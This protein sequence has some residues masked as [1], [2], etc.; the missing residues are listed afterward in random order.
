MLQNK[1]SIDTMKKIF[2]LISLVVAA[3]VGKL[4]AQTNYTLDLGSSFS[5]AWGAPSYSGTASNIGGS[6]INCTMA[7]ALTGSGSIVS[8]YPRV[9]NNNTNGSDFQVQGST[10]AMEID[11]N[12]GNKTSYVDITYTF[13]ASVQ[14]LNFGISDIDMPGGSSPY[15]YVD[16]ITVT[17]YDANGNSV[18]PSLSKYNTSSTVFGI[19]SNTATGSTTGGSN[20]GS[21]TQGSPSQDGTMFVNFNGNAIKSITVRY[22]TLNSALVATNPGL[23]AIAVG[24]LTFQKATAPVTS[25]VSNS[26]IRNTS[27]PTTIS[28]LTGTDDESVSSFTIVTL[29]SATAGTLSYNNGTS[30]VSV[31]AGQVLTPAQAAS[32]KF[33]PLATYTGT[34]S[35]TYTA[36][37]NRALVSNTSTFS[38]PV[39]S[40]LLPVT[41]TNVSAVLSNKVIVVSWTTHGEYNASKFIVEKSTDG[42]NWQSIGEVA[43]AGNSTVQKDYTLTDAQVMPVN[44]YRLKEV[45]LDGSYIY[46]KLVS[47]SATAAHGIQVDIYPNPVT[48]KATIRTSSDGNK[49]V[50]IAVFNSNGVRVQMLNTQLIAGTNQIELKNVNSLPPG[51]YTVMMTNNN[52]S[53]AVT[54]FIKQ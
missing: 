6:G 32:L 19:S 23:Q 38:I 7:V 52:E 43:A 42:S 15:T 4:E 5:P 8:P 41:F 46:S 36:T 13:S 10:D 30:Y 17:G 51:M 20:V 25:N 34:A 28:A 24:N 16:Q 50:Q 2:T 37:D 48:N 14:N 22:T 18:L 47:V 39:T 27:G 35:F 11:I 9:N 12:L 3:A 40:S 44:Y 21:L 45:D 29:P 31:T 53:P 54:R 26:S 49:S 1:S 33:T